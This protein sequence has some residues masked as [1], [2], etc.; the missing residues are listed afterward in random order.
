M[1]H[2]HVDNKIHAVQ[3]D[4]CYTTMPLELN[5]RRI[6]CLAFMGGLLSFTWALG[7]GFAAHELSQQ[8]KGHG[9][10]FDMR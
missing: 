7:N 4:S 2:L 3:E 1:V 5:E 10:M 6:L 9:V 8:L